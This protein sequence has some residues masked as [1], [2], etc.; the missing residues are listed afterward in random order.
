[1]IFYVHFGLVHRHL[2]FFKSIR[3]LRKVPLSVIF[4]FIEA[5]VKFLVI[6]LV[7][8]VKTAVFSGPIVLWNLFWDLR[9]GWR[10]AEE[11]VPN[12]RRWWTWGTSMLRT[13]VVEGRTR[14]C[15]SRWTE[16]GWQVTEI[17]CSYDERECWKCNTAGC[18]PSNCERTLGEFFWRLN[19]FLLSFS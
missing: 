2:M 8:I 16:V 10:W 19:K 12:A 11:M 3:W 17:R 7:F 14:G 13:F 5:T 1:M 4:F 6:L 15:W 9:R 18:N